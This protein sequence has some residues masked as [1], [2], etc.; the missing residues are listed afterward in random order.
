MT[1]DS[2]QD[3]CPD[4]EY[5]VE[6]IL[7]Q[8][9]YNGSPVYLVKWKGWPDEQCTWEPAESFL[10][11]ATLKEWREALA[12][13][14]TLNEEEVQQL[15]NKMDKWQ[16]ENSN[17]RSSQV[18]R[19]PDSAPPKPCD[20]P[21]SRSESGASDSSQEVWQPQQKLPKTVSVHFDH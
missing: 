9:Y 15:Q 8:D 19:D 3:D 5:E 10:Q 7:A 16:R 17:S 4:N 1:G 2:Q 20:L 13:H 12:K 14:D 6:R 11:E 21:D 18:E